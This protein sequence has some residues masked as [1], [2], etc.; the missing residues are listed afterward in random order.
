[1][2]RH[3]EG[4]TSWNARSNSRMMMDVDKENRKTWNAKEKGF[5]LMLRQQGIPKSPWTKKQLGKHGSLE[6]LACQGETRSQVWSWVG[7]KL[8]VANGWVR[9]KKYRKKAPRE[10]TECYLDYCKGPR[11]KEWLRYIPGWLHTKGMRRRLR[12]PPTWHTDVVDSGCSHPRPKVYRW[13]SN[14]DV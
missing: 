6:R 1:M 11:I 4:R 8:S 2:G 5:D 14:L 3:P 10:I 9:S 7:V 13:A 12:S